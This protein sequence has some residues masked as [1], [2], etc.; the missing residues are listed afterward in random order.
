MSHEFDS[1]IDSLTP[2]QYES[3]F[4]M[5]EAEYAAAMDD[6]PESTVYSDDELED[7]AGCAVLNDGRRLKWRHR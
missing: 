7:M 6:C 5:T 1:Y 2:A 4:G 3:Q